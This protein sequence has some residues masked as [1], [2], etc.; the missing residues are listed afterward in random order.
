MNNSSTLQAIYISYDGMTDPLGQSQVLPYLAELSKKGISFDLISFEKEANFKTHF[1]TIETYCQAHHIHWHP[2]KYTKKPPLL[3]T[4]YDLARMRKATKRLIKTKHI[5]IIHCR[6]YIA[7]LIGLELKRKK[8]IPFLFDMRGFWA[9]ERI[10]GNIWSKNS[11]VFKHVYT[12]F[13]KRELEFFKESDHII[14]L[15]EEGKH[16][17]VKHI[18]PSI[19]PDKI[20][21]IPC[22][23]NLNLFDPEKVSESKLARLKNEL[24]IPS[25]Q[26]ILGYVGSIGTWYMLPEMLDYFVHLKRFQPNAIFLFVTGEHPERI[27]KMAIEKGITRESIRITSCSHQAVPAYI[28]LFNL[29]IFFIKPAYSKKASSPTKQGELMAMGIPLVCNDGVGD[30]AQVVR[31]YKAGFVVE[32][33]T[34]ENYEHALPH[35][36]SFEKETAQSG[37]QYFYSLDEG[38]KRYEN[39]YKKLVTSF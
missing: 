9:D 1:K 2:L 25:D 23:V 8:G 26:F 34:P 31:T 17:I 29:S 11:P 4:L 20:T 5:S 7:A 13:K 35:N 15:T 38:A 16:E 3:S 6:S 30:T 24:N 39:V 14:S 22:C 32:G 12:F 10:D 27:L 37:A 19:N 33:F 36:I 21:I 18:L 28:K